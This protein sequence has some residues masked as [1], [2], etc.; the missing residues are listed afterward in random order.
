MKYKIIKKILIIP[1]ST[2]KKKG[3]IMVETSVTITQQLIFFEPF[4]VEPDND[5]KEENQ[6]A[7]CPINKVEERNTN[8]D[9]I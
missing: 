7:I 4:I 5:K 1:C 3:L 6:D 9:P 2:T 8:P